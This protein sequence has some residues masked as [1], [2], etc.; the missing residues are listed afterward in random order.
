MQG[1]GQGIQDIM[2]RSRDGLKLHARRY[3]APTSGR[4]PVVCL[5][6]LTRNGRDF[7]ELAS[8]L[9]QAGAYA[10]DVYTLDYRGRGFSE[11][12]S[13]WKNYAVPIEALDVIDLM[14]LAHLEKPAII[15]TS[16]GGL[17]TMVMAALQPSAVGP[18]VLNDIGPV[19]QF[20]GLTRIASYVGRIPMPRTWDEAAQTAHSINRRRFPNVSEEQWMRVAKQWFNEKDGRPAHG[21]DPQL[22][23]A[24]SVLDGPVP[25]LWPQYSALTR[26][27]LMVVRGENSDILSEETVDEMRRRH[28]ALVSHTV[29]GEGHAPLLMDAPTQ[30]AVLHFLEQADAQFDWIGARTGTM[31]H[32]HGG[33]LV[34]RL[35]G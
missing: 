12:D 18:V 33:G 14:T 13:D 31:P 1:H 29:P 34:R 16:R 32:P 20:D 10:R 7:H 35:A 19:I 28:P 24:L 30:E 6:G 9:S 8:Y 5:A 21:Y 25:A 2:F 26:V 4:R 27:P 17:I 3:G 15:G 11:W 23:N 22:R